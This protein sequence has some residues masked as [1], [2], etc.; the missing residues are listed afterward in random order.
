MAERMVRTQIYLSP[1]VYAELKR[2]A[3]KY[4]VTL[5]IQIR[6]ALEAYIRSSN[7]EA[8]EPI[9]DPN[10]PIFELIKHAGHGPEDLSENHDKYLYSDPHGEESLKRSQSRAAPPPVRSTREKPTAYRVKPRRPR[11]KQGRRK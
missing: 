1:K 10:D 6:E 3:E 7:G 11:Q 4:G 9:L 8:D 5:A 2:R